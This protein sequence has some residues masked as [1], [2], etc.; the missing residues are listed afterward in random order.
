MKRV[1]WITMAVML[2]TIG[3]GSG[4][5]KATVEPRPMPKGGTFTGVW[6]SP[7]YGRMDL[8]QSGRSVI[9]QYTKDE[10][11][12]RI[13]GVA[14]GNLLRFKWFEKREMIIGRPTEVRGRGYFRYRE[15]QDGAKIVGEWGHDADELGGGPWNA[16][17][18]KT[19]RPNLSSEAEA[20]PEEAESVEDNGADEEPSDHENG[21]EKTKKKASEEELNDLGLP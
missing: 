9:G 21:E 14:R 4:P 10:R 5:K 13:E 6:F 3:C 12:G 17:R 18:S 15:D 7:Q 19:L 20:S 8:V 16:A 1:K 2:W 11:Q